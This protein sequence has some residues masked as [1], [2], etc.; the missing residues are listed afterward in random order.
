NGA[1]GGT[2]ILR[3]GGN[4]TV[5]SASGVGG[6]STAATGYGGTIN[7]SAAGAL[8]SAPAGTFNIDSSSVT[9]K[10]GNV[11][12][13]SGGNVA[14]ASL[15]VGNINT[16]GATQG[17]Q[18]EVVSLD[19]SA[20]TAQIGNIRS[21]SSGISSQGGSVGIASFGTLAVGSI[22]TTNT[23]GSASATARSGDVFL[24]SGGASITMGQITANNANGSGSGEVILVTSG[25]TISGPSPVAGSAAM[26]GEFTNYV[27]PSASISTG[28]N[29]TV[30]I[31]P[32]VI[33]GYNPHGFTSV[34]IG[35]ILYS[36]TGGDS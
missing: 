2:V 30:T 18:V 32:S 28:G 26:I 9:S 21:T 3:S 4:L 12:L 7:I 15:T 31:K 17:G 8:L 24:S 10:G 14:G 13:G 19:P 1:D 25:S 35:G 34:G 5:G 22:N 33:T 29:W 23:N 27:A 11:V 36:D 16:S 6:I 20:G